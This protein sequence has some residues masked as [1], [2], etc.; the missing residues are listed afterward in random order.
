MKL[1]VRLHLG[2]SGAEVFVGGKWVSA[3]AQVLDN[4]GGILRRGLR[5]Q[6]TGLIPRY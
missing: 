6:V 1:K 5:D 4:V 3:D 2:T